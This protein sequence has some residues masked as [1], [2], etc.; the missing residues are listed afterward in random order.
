M[1][2]GSP[3]GWLHKP[4]TIAMTG[5]VV[6]GCKPRSLGCMLCFA[7]RSVVRQAHYP[8]RGDI[9]RHN[10]EGRLEWTGIVK[11]FPERVAAFR[12]LTKPHTI[13]VTALGELFD[14]Q[15]TMEFLVDLWQTMADTPH[16]TYIILTKL[17]GRM[18]RIVSKLVE[19]FGILPNVWLGVSAENQDQANKRLLWLMRTPA[20]IRVVSCE[21]MLGPIDLTRIPA[22][23]RQQ[24]GMVWDLLN[25][26]YGVPGQ[27]KARL[28]VGLDWVIV[29]GESGRKAEARAMHPQWA[30]DT[31]NDAH[32]AGV[33]V[34]FKQWG[35]WGPAPWVVRVCDP[36]E[37]WKGTDD[38]LAEAKKAAEKIGATHSLP[39]WADQYDMLPREVD[40]RPWS[41]ER[42]P[43][44]DGEP[45]A[46]L[47]FYPNTSAGHGLDG[48]T[49]QQ[50]PDGAGGIID[51][52]H[53]V[54]DL[55]K[56]DR[57]LVTSD[58][59]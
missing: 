22:R 32:R 54:P 46:P 33:A 50:W 36:E 28:D 42:Q 39:V 17:A 37:G 59:T 4:G 9:V 31:I 18:Y 43:L 20:A 2:E 12:T 52:S 10:E 51:I 57:E 44:A 25:R 34:F 16:H 15:V 55:A 3:I 49:W 41:L 30:R 40:H 35:S 13:F 8:G 58:A 6:L 7:P 14:P 5:N 47:R 21:P 38:E 53:D 48:R 11:M 26:R 56:L 1:S 29:G 27:W 23:S 19:Q 24:P 45:H